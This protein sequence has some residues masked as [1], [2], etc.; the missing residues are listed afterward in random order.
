MP[1]AFRQV[2]WHRNSLGISTTI[3]VVLPL[4]HKGRHKVTAA[5]DRL[6]LATRFV[7]V[8]PILFLPVT[9]YLQGDPYE[10]R[11]CT[12]QAL[13]HPGSG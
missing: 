6:S 13:S 4:T 9:S 10:Q 5:L 2:D 3:Q 7:I 1:F 11:K 8:F 12:Y